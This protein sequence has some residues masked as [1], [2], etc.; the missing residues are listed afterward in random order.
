MADDLAEDEVLYNDLVPIIYCSKCQQLNGLEG[1]GWTLAKV[2]RVCMLAGP[3][4]LVSKCYRCNKCPGNNCKDYQFRAHDEGVI[5]QLPAALESSL[6][7]RFTQHGAVEVSLMDFLLRNVSS[8]VSF[9]DSTDAVQELHY[10]T[11]NRSKL[12]HLQ[13]TAERGRL[14]QKRS[15]FFMGSAGA[16]AQVPQPPDF[17]AYKDR[18]GYRGWV[19]SRSYL[20]RMLLAYL[21]ERLA[22]TKERLAMVDEVYLRGDHTFRSASKVKTAEGGKAYEA[23]YTV[24]NEFSQVAAQWMVGDTSFREIEGGL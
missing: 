5:K 3:A 19:P 23:V 21:T 1:D 4:F 11:Y 16:S 7:I 22:W 12:G 10:I 2:R 14:A 8:G 13:Y 20:T 15:S 24:M 6:N 17:G 18:Q 9:A